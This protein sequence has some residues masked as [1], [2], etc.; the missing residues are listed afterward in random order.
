[1]TIKELR[2]KYELSQAKLAKALGVSASMI[3]A[4]ESGQRKVSEKIAAAVKDVYGEVIEVAAK[5]EEVKNEAEKTVAKVEKKT[6]KAKAET[7]AA[8]AQI[9][10]KAK[11]TR[12]KVEKK[13]KEVEKK[14]EAVVKKP[15]VHIQSPMG[16]EIS[17]E[18]ILKKVGDVDD[19]YVRVDENKAYWVKGDQTGSVDL[20]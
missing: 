8:A 19:V 1:M 9:G 4:I 16:G 3:G 18:E 20:W 17:P 12:A 6:K 2:E 15:A 13:V 10:K 7:A 5:A 14:I 11:T